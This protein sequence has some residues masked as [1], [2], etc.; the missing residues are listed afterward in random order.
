MSMGISMAVT[1]DQLLRDVK[2]VNRLL[3][4]GA[5][6][7]ALQKRIV[8]DL[9]NRG[10]ATYAIEARR[11]LATFQTLQNKHLEH[12]EKLLGELEALNHGG[13]RLAAE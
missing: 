10:L 6:N 7:M 2:Q 12:R 9:T 11:L 4:R 3:E 1:P 5:E 13:M 8:A